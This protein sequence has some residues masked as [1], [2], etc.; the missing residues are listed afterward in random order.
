MCNAC[1]LKWKTRGKPKEGYSSNVFPPLHQVEVKTKRKRNTKKQI[2]AKKPRVSNRV[3]CDSK[4]TN[5]KKQQ[6]SKIPKEKVVPE[7]KVIQ[8]VVP[9][10]DNK[11]NA[12]HCCEHCQKIDTP[13]WRKGPSGPK[14]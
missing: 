13:L 12:I 3:L 14:S 11:E 8:D 10:E 5:S 4:E 7:E 9:E 2:P 1:G 6:P